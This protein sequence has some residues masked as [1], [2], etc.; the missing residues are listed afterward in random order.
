M[1]LLKVEQVARQLSVTPRIVYKWISEGR[2]AGIRVGEK[3]VRV[4]ERE[5]DFFLNRERRREVGK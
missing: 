1:T 3:L 2:L 4:D 5:L